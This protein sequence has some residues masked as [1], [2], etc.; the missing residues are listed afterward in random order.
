MG[1]KERIKNRPYADLKPYYLGFGVGLH[2]QDL[3]LSNN[4]I[5]LSGGETLFA[6][7]PEW[8]PGFQVGV[9]LGR[10]FRPGLELRLMPTLYFG[11]KRVAYS[12]G[13]AEQAS[14]LLR[15]TYISVP[16]QLKY[17]ALRLNNLRPYIGAGGYAALSLGGRRGEEL[18]ERALDYGIL[19]SVGCDFYLRYFTLSPEL[20]FSYGL[21]NVIDLERKDLEDDKRMR[22][23][24]ALSGGRTKMIALIFNF[25]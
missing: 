25:H 13:Q 14:F 1:Q 24:Q 16:L 6:E 5:V 17:A 7:V 20:T 10:V 2:T 18:R 11:D 22:Y 15:S 9:H 3:R 23:T 8:R 21:P 12:D 19:L 4:G